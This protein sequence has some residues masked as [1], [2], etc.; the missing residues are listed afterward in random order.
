MADYTLYVYYF[1]LVLP[2]EL[3]QS[4][5]FR[6]ALSPEMQVLSLINMKKSYLKIVVDWWSKCPT[7]KIVSTLNALI[8]KRFA[9]PS[10][11]GINLMRGLFFRS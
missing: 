9:V 10:D 1:L 8:Q 6:L 4:A 7:G 3:F 11:G 2:R 5:N